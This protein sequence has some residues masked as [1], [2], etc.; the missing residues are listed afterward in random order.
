MIL[1]ILKPMEKR[2]LLSFFLGVRRF[3]GAGFLVRVLVIG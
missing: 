2:L 3:L 1:E